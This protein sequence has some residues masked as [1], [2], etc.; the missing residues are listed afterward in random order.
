M[1]TNGPQAIGGRFSR[2]EGS[3]ETAFWEAAGLVRQ[4]RVICGHINGSVKKDSEGGWACFKKGAEEE[5][6]NSTL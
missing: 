5:E 6:K 4:K 3:W 1:C 2:A